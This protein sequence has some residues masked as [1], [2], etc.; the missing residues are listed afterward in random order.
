[1]ITESYM[2]GSDVY[3]IKIGQNKMENWGLLDDSDPD[4]IWFH[5][6]GAPS[7]YVVLNTV[8][9]MKQVPTR[10]LYRCAVL[11]KMRSKSAKE[12]NCNVNYTYVKHVTKG[13]HE[14]EAII[15]HTKVIRV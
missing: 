10:V 1:M 11:C 7:A 3:V 2:D 14:G 13:E 15:K 6:S 4:N 9:N 12:C 5:V 8:C